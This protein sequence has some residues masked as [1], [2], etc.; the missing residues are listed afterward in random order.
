MMKAGTHRVKNSSATKNRRPLIPVFKAILT[1]FSEKSSGFDGNR[2][3]FKKSELAQSVDF[4]RKSGEF[5]NA[6]TYTC[7][8]MRRHDKSAVHDLEPKLLTSTQQAEQHQQ[9]NASARADGPWSVHVNA[10]SMAV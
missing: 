5:V 10:I 7:G 3:V 2:L 8:P 4:H 6:G 1:D 9:T